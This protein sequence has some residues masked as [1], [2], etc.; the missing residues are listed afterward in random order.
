MS[1]ARNDCGSCACQLRHDALR[2]VFGRA[3][4]GHRQGPYVSLHDQSSRSTSEGR[5]V[6]P[7]DN[8][9]VRD[10]V[11][12]APPTLVFADILAALSYYRD[13]GFWVAKIDDDRV[14]VKIQG[15][16]LWLRRALSG[17]LADRSRAAGEADVSILVDR[18]YRLLRQICDRNEGHV[19][20][21]GVHGFGD[22][23]GNVIAVGPTRD[24]TGRMKRLVWP[25]VV[26]EL[27]T[28]WRKWRSRRAE[29]PHL[30]AFQEFYR[31][32]PDKHNVYYMFFTGGLLNWVAKSVS[33]VPADVNLVL[34][35]SALPDYEQQW[36]RDKL[37]RPFFHLDLR[38]DDVTVWEFLFATNEH[39][40]GWLDIDCLVFNSALFEE[41]ASV[42]D[43]TY[44]NGIWWQETGL[45]F[46]V[47]R[48]YFQFVNI[49]AV[50]A[51][52]DAGFRVT[53]NH[54]SFPPYP[55]HN[56]LVPGRRCYSDVVT[57]PLRRQ[58]RRL[59]PP[60]SADQGVVGPSGL[61]IGGR[62]SGFFDTTF[63]F[64][65]MARS[66]GFDGRMVRRLMWSD[67][68]GIDEA[69]DEVFHVGGISSINSRSRSDL[70]C[71]L[72]DYVGLLGAERLPGRY[73][74]RQELVTARLAQHG[75]TPDTAL[76]EVRKY[77]I[78]ERNLSEKIA[79]AVLRPPATI[80]R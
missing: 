58:L 9:S 72:A 77:L 65:A 18:P 68:R 33:Q 79:D 56:R 16:K 51:L 49:A 45:G 8:Q 61:F 13:L 2:A 71:V 63:L 5:T 19:L 62:T 43:K 52:R 32:L 20:A 14:L 11:P 69:S 35:G 70:R 46:S 12:A 1:F 38:V 23:A 27:R 60:D 24:L 48:T 36:V 10:S 26:D 15:T 73:R 47:T 53:P 80:L 66:M 28:R 54:Y 17:E 37:G 3:V 64:Q 50:N 40:F 41:M 31:Q 75:L 39:S 29:A 57:R 6:H 55:L 7:A 25:P 74:E 30:H 78:G 67:T 4:D 34:I 42:A 22:Y 76:T 44:A 21:G 59:V